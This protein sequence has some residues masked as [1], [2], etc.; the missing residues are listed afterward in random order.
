MLNSTYNL[1]LKQFM[2]YFYIKNGKF[3]SMHF[4]NPNALRSVELIEVRVD[5]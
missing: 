1:F 4:R 2:Y 5:I 3:L